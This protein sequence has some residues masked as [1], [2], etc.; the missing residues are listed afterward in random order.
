MTNTATYRL[1]AKSSI[2]KKVL[3]GLFAVLFFL[4]L[5]LSAAEASRLSL[6][7]VGTVHQVGLPGEWLKHDLAVAIADAA[8]GREGMRVCFVV[9]EGNGTLSRHLVPLGSAGKASTRWMLDANSGSEPQHV[10]A[11]VVDLKTMDVLSDT[12]VFS[13]CMAG[14]SLLTRPQPLP[15]STPKLYLTPKPDVLSEEAR[16][17]AAMEHQPTIVVVNPYRTIISRIQV[18]HSSMKPRQVQLSLGRIFSLR[19]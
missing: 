17:A 1:I 19:E 12:V 6:V 11:Y 16:V 7:A 18:E 3:A 4:P 13:A 8:E 10:M 2:L 9:R 14:E 5:T 15:D